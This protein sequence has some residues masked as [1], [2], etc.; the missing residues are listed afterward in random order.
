MCSRNS[1]NWNKLAA[2][3]V[4]FLVLEAGIHLSIHPSFAKEGEESSYPSRTVTFFVPYPPGGGLD[5]NARLLAKY[6]S[7]KIGQTILVINKPGGLGV[8]GYLEYFSATNPDL[9]TLVPDGHSTIPL[10]AASMPNLP[11]DIWNRAWIGRYV[12]EEAFYCVPANSPWKTLS[13]VAMAA[14][15]DPENFKWGTLG[16]GGTPRFAC[17]PLFVEAGIEEKKT[18]MI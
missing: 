14:K 5:F 18:K 11:F 17:A 3:S 13:D 10:M 6:A 9:Y 2:I 7:K 8:T 16:G 1:F 12:I 15:K 4:I